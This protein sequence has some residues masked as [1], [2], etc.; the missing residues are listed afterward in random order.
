MTNTAP[1]KKRE[2]KYDSY[3]MF[4]GAAFLMWL[5][6]QFDNAPAIAHHQL[7]LSSPKI[8]EAPLKDSVVLV[9]QHRKSDAMGLILNRPAGDGDHFIGGPMETDKKVYALHSLEMQLPDSLIMKDVGLGI[10]EGQA[11]VDKLVAAKPKWYRVIKGYVGWGKRQLN[12]EIKD[13]VWQVVIY[14]KDFVFDT[15]PEEMYATAQKLPMM[16]QTH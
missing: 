14:D 13:G 7:L 16:Q 4:A 1:K 12:D 15:K 2:G 3:L 5:G 9:L 6:G 8:T 10:V 11:S